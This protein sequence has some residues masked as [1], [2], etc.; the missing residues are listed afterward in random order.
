MAM[1]KPAPDIRMGLVGYRDRGDEYVTKMTPLT[2]DLDQVY[3]DL[4]AYQADGGG[5]GPESVQS[6]PP[7]SRPQEP[8]G[9]GRKRSIGRYSSWATSHPTWTTRTT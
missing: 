4:M 5:D 6:G 2:H 8:A 1:S 3:A 7:R 9:P